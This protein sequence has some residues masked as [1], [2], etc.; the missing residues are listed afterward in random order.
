MALLAALLLA[1]LAAC[2]IGASS[3]PGSFPASP[4]ELQGLIPEEVNGIALERLSMRGNEFVSSGQAT[5]ETQQFLEGLGVSPD[6]ISVAAG[7]GA[8]Q[9]GRLAVVFIFRADGAAPDRLL[10]AFQ[11]AAAEERGAALGWQPATVGGKTVERAMDP[12]EPGQS[13][14]LYA[15][16]SVLVFVAATEQDDAAK[17]LEAMP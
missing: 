8:A 3:N 7:F 1:T 6:A 5:D 17:V 15:R 12:G 14:Y 2:G 4:E 16:E 10:A 13:L 11:D 9:D